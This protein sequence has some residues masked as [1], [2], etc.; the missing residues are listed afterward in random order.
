LHKVRGNIDTNFDE[1]IH[2]AFVGIYAINNLR[3]Y[4]PNFVY[5]F[6]IFRYP[7]LFQKSKDC[8]YL[9]TELIPG[10]TWGKF[11]DNCIID[12]FLNIL[13]Q[14]CLSLKLAI[15]LYD[16]THYDLH[17]GNVIIRK[18]EQPISIKYNDDIINT[19]H[20]ATIIDFGSSHIQI[21]GVNYGRILKNGNIHNFSFWEHDIFKFL[22]FT[23]KHIDPYMIKEKISD[24]L[25]EAINTVDDW[26]EYFYNMGWPHPYKKSN[27]ES[28]NESSDESSNESSE[29]YLDNPS[30]IKAVKSLDD[31]IKKL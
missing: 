28:S 19:Q 9:I 18:V 15:Q 4:I 20:I 11:V 5:T 17:S 7:C 10:Q 16:F 31:D 3:N 30:Y 6:E 25:Q 26:D 29:N 22:G 13:L 2:E 21:D 24:D 14:I 27:E 8:N 23:W 1:N 12:E